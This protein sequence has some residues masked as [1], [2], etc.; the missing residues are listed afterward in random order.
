ME[1]PKTIILPDGY[2]GH[3]LPF[4]AEPVETDRNWIK[5]KCAEPSLEYAYK[6]ITMEYYKKYSK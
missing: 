5:L 1:K 2:N 6:W 4:Y 3:T